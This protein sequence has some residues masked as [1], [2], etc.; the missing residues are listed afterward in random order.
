[1]FTKLGADKKRR[2]WIPVASVESEISE[3]SCKQC[4]A[5][6]DSRQKSVGKKKVNAFVE[7]K[8]FAGCGAG[9]VANAAYLSQVTWYQ[10]GQSETDEHRFWKPAKYLRFSGAF[11]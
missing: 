5:I 2:T 10:I 9:G 6:R 4:S 3:L 7:G 8:A 1:M 11:F